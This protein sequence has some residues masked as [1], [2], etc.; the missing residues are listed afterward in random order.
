MRFNQIVRFKRD[1]INAGRPQPQKQVLLAK[2]SIAFK[3]M[4]NNLKSLKMGTTIK[5]LFKN[6]YNKYTTSSSSPGGWSLVY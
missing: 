3:K 1:S 5:E 2:T 4:I 6:G